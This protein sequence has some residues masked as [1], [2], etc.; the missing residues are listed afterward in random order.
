[1]ITGSVGKK[2]TAKRLS[3]QGRGAKRE[4]NALTEKVLRF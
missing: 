4:T 2:F 1:M 3:P